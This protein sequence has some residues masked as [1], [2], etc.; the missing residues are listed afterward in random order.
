ML[1]PSA[2]L[3]LTLKLCPQG[4]LVLLFISWYQLSI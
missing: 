1:I 3:T 2:F 4:G